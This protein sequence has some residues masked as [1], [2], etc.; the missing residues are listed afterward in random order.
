MTD[1][2]TL[3]GSSSEAHGINNAGQVA[4]FSTTADGDVHGYITGPNGAG[5]TE[6]GTLGG[7]WSTGE[8]IN[9]AGQ[10]AGS[11]ETANGASHAFISG[12][13]GTGMTDLGTLGGDMSSAMGINDAGQV[14]GT[15]T[16]A[17]GVLH[18]FIT[19]PDGAGMTMLSSLVL[20]KNQVLSP[21]GI[22]SAGLVAANVMLIPEPSSYALMLAG[23][24]LIGFMAGRRK[25]K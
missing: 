21:V 2:G 24:G 17:D 15:S 14:V 9:A 25:P 6:L 1:L 8:G 18:G 4:G 23:L 22:N 20:E 12:P 19:G 13:N 3:G 5:M 7:T 11:S 10:V 16:T